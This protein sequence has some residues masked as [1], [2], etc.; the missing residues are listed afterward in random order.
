VEL[1]KLASSILF[2]SGS[3]VFYAKYTEQLN[4]IANLMTL[5]NDLKFQIQGHTD[6][7]G[8]EESNKKLSLKRVTKILSF[9]VSKGVNQLNLSVKGFGETQPVDTNNT[10]EGRAK[11]RRVEIKI[12]N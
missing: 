6:N 7:V 11:N 4:E 9:L 12:L 10:A 5:H 8:S 3:D 2:I 1:T